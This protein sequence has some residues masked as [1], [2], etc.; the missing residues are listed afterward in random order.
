M[1]AVVAGVADHHAGRLETAG[2]HA[3]NAVAGEQRAHP[4]AQLFLQRLHHREALGAG[5]FHDVAEAR[6][7]VGGQGGVV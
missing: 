4:A 1:H 3:L 2:R 5:L 6:Q 7:A